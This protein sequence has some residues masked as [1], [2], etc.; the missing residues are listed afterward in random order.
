VPGLNAA[1]LA[2]FGSALEGVAA[3]GLAGSRRTL[4][5]EPISE[6]A[7]RDFL[8]RV[9]RERLAGLLG[10]AI[11]DGVFPATDEQIDDAAAL[12][13]EVAV[14]ALLLE[15]LLL[16]VADRFDAADLDFRVL[17]GPSVAHV[18]YPEPSIRSF[19]DLD[20]LVR[21]ADFG[22][23]VEVLE[24]NGGQRGIPELRHGF[25]HRFGKGAMIS[26]PDDL[27][28]DLHRS[29]VAGPLGMT[30]DVEGLFETS[31]AFALADRHL[32]GL[33][34]E[35]R[36]LHACI[37]AGLGR[38]PRLHSLRDVAQMGLGANLDID[39][40]HGL[41]RSWRATA[42]VA[43]AVN[44]AWTGLDLA[45]SV[46]L[47]AW[48]AR[49]RPDRDEQRLL[50]AYIGG[51]QSFTRQ[52][53]ATLRVIPRRRDKVAYV[54]SL[55][56]PQRQYLDARNATRLDHVRRGSAHLRWGILR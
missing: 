42:V 17:K 44:L 6:P 21:A 35:E 2:G 23:A 40:V 19:G 34:A 56:Y 32:A 52:A 53:I 41:A 28:I 25:D 20:L 12:Q 26:M 37:H 27:E 55:V 3:Y 11:H 18:D 50:D 9:A 48:A 15:R 5:A 45:D 4:P 43:R 7:W 22:R 47:S 14:V 16:M 51:D 13:T 30:I 54:R 49:Y 10:L 36:F 31:T 39:R 38:P 29:F 8:D 46:A 24:A 1:P 33:G